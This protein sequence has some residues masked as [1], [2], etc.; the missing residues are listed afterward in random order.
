MKKKLNLLLI[1]LPIFLGTHSIA[2]KADRWTE[3]YNY[4]IQ[5]GLGN[6]RRETPQDF[7]KQWAA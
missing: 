2:I 7:C 3:R 4:C 6:G 1:L 5:K